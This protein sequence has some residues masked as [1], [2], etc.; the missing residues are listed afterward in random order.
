MKEELFK[1]NFE[2]FNC[3][4]HKTETPFTLESVEYPKDRFYNDRPT[5][6]HPLFIVDK[7]TNDQETYLENYG[8][9]LCS[10]TK[11]HVLVVVEKDGDKVSLKVFKGSR[12]RRAGNS[13]FKVSWNVDYLTV[14]TKTGDVYYGYLHDYQKKMKCTKM[15]KRN[16]FKIEPVNLM[17]NTIK[18]HLSWFDAY[19]YEIVIEA[20]SKFMYAI[21]YRNDFE[22]LDF[23]QR[24]FRFYLGKRNVKYPNNFYVYASQFIGPEIKKILKKNDGRLVDSFMIKQGLTGKKLKKALHNC[25]NLNIDLYKHAKY[26]FGDDWINQE[27]IIV[28]LLDSRHSPQRV[29]SEFKNLI[30]DE[31][32][33]R[34][35]SI[36]KRVFVYED[37]DAY[38]F[39]DH[40]RMYTELKMY[41]EVDLRWQSERQ[42]DFFRQEHLDWTDKIQ[43]YKQGHYSRFYPKYLIDSIEKEIDGVT[44]VLLTDSHSY[45]DESAVQSNCVKTYIGKPSSLVVSLRKGIFGDRATIEYRLTK[46]GDEINVDR[47]Q[48]LGKYNT[49]LGEEW[50]GVLLKLDKVVLS[51]VRDKRFETVK[52]HKKCMNGVE[53][54]SDTHWE[55]GLLRWTHKNI[56][57]T[58]SNY[59]FLN[60]F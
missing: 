28:N 36:F 2:K 21:D 33:K 53:L 39:Y 20:I 3:V 50:D 47:V 60:Q 6:R 55:N 1:Y 25:E 14:N 32:L 27:D 26:L 22:D 41:G 4:S 13:W 5:Q 42:K 24:L 19:K 30:T 8:N 35:Y 44:P 52:I 45:N 54:N 40:I 7:A 51:S 48:S 23:N 59:F 56:E 37:L 34:V 57:S 16:F 11:A 9:P 29:P 18:M 17:K 31:E 12:H 58:Q 43:F 46:K 15:L 49:K 10:V 38:T